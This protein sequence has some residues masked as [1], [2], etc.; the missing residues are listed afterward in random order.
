MGNAF[1]GKEWNLLSAKIYVT[2]A[3]GGGET[4]NVHARA[5]EKNQ[6]K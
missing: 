5:G 4:Q 1:E 3:F 2:F 6:S